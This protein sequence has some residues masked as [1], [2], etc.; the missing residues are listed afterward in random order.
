MSGLKPMSFHDHCIRA[1]GYGALVI[2]CL[3]LL[4]MVSALLDQPMPLRAGEWAMLAVLAAICIPV[5]AIGRWIIGK[6][7]TGQRS[8]F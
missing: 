5:M 4:V 1:I 6:Y 7:R 3:A 2:P 8:G